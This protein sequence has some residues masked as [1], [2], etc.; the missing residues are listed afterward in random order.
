MLKQPKVRPKQSFKNSIKLTEQ[1]HGESVKIQNILSNYERTGLI[2]HINRREPIFADW[3]SAPDY[4]HAQKIIADA[5][6]MFEQVP[7]QIR[8]QFANDPAQF[9]DFIQNPE[10]KQAMEDLG[11]ETSHIPEDYEKPLSEDEKNQVHLEDMIEQKMQERASQKLS[12]ASADQ[13]RE[14]LAILEKKSNANA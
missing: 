1:H 5:N 7:A 9:L 12:E 11:I 6:S 3:T 14:Q 8:A 2:T 13:L 10:N 4:Y